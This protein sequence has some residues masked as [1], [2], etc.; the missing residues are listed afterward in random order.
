MME[1]F[2]ATLPSSTSVFTDNTLSH[3]ITKLRRPLELRGEW[4]V[5]LVEIT[6][7]TFWYNLDADHCRFSVNVNEEGWQETGVPPGYF[8]DNRYLIDLLNQSGQAVTQKLKTWLHYNQ[9]ERKVLFQIPEGVKVK[10]YRGLAHVLGLNDEQ[11]IDN[12]EN[13]YP[14]RGVDLNHGVH[15]IFIY[16]DI[17]HHQLVG[18][19]E[20]PLLRAVRMKSFTGGDR[21]EM[22][23]VVYTHPHYLPVS[24]QYIETIE[25]D[26]RTDTGVRI[27]YNTGKVISKLHFRQRKP[28]F[29]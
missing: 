28:D 16:T 15:A 17:I 20:V 3:Y 7:P 22:D 19:A 23:T 14:K 13:I 21:P 5:A 1:D 25:I 6:T 8:S 29:L 11:I 12:S 18:D 27:P 9:Y 4:E 24:K 2:F 26:I 10:I